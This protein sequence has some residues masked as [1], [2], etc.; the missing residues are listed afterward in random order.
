MGEKSPIENLFRLMDKNGDGFMTK[1][2]DMN[3]LFSEL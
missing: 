3:C 2:V 1:K